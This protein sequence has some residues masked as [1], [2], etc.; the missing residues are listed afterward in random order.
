MF[1]SNVVMTV[2]LGILCN[3]KRSVTPGQNVTLPST[4]YSDQATSFQSHLVLPTDGTPF[5]AVL[6]PDPAWHLGM[7]DSLS[8][9]VREQPIVSQA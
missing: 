7:F 2:R 4:Q 1:L 5:P 8:G 6:G 9:M 3:H